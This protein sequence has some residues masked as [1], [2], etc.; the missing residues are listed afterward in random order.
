MPIALGV[1]WVCAAALFY[2]YLGYPLLIRMAASMCPI[3]VR[4]RIIRPEVSVLL[5]A[6]DEAPVIAR[7]IEN[8]LALDYP[9]E[10]VEILIGSDGSRDSTVAI[11]RRYRNAGVRVF[12]F[13]FRRGKAA[14]LNELAGMARGEILVLADARQRFDPAFIRNIVAPFEDSNV[15]AVSG[16]LILTEDPDETSV[17][18]G[19]GFYWRYEKQ[20][21]RSES[22]VDSTVGV[23]GAAYAI[24][25]SLFE[26][27]PPDTILDDVVIPARVVRKGYRVLFE[28]SARAWDRLPA[29]PQQEF[30]R[31]VRTIAGNYQIFARERWLWKPSVNRLWL[32]TYSHKLLRLLSPF[33]FGALVVA[34]I[35][36]APRSGFY[37]ATLLAAGLFVAAALTGRLSRRSSGAR[38][39]RSAFAVPYFVFLLNWATV[40]GFFRFIGGTQSVIWERAAAGARQAPASGELE[41]ESALSAVRAA[42][43]RSA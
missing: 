31:K 37:V 7:R 29:T 41:A 40:V 2:L 5:V 27:I 6:Q 24:R 36:L 32:Q 23:T 8:L 20:I 4:R 19:A 15:G 18:A 17:A 42:D 21:R 28:P 10:R 38:R 35:V 30:T 3:P 12:A 22:R 16:E 26:V 34:N 39:W 1:F 14:V 25:R 13:R 11:A 43:R 9:R 33:L